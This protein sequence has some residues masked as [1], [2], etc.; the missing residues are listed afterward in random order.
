MKKVT[1]S[2]VS[3]KRRYR[4]YGWATAM[5]LHGCKPIDFVKMVARI[6]NS[7]RLE[8]LSDIEI[9]EHP[10]EKIIVATYNTEVIWKGTIEEI[11]VYRKQR[12]SLLI[13][14]FIAKVNEISIK[15]QVR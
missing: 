8:G 9:I 13:E 12:A 2:K 7:E 1:K 6:A 15:R 5:Y 14:L 11:N 3:T 10:I 4:S